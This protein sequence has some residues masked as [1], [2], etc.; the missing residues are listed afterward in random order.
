MEQILLEVVLSNMENREVIWESQHG[1]TKDKSC[2]TNL[3]L[4]G[5]T[6]DFLCCS[7]YISGHEKVYRCHLSGLLDG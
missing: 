5:N 4:D 3:V 6:S 2:L 7:D 1:F